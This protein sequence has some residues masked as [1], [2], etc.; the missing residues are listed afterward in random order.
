MTSSLQRIRPQYHFRPGPNGLQA[1]DVR[2]LIA[3]SAA[4]D[5]QQVPLASLQE[6]DETWRYD[7]D[8]PTVRSVV[9]HMRLV[10]AADVSFPILLCADGRLMDGMHRVAR[11]LLSNRETIAARRFPE[12][13]AP[14]FIGVAPSNL[15][16]ED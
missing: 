11:A 5:I 1:W 2:K 15:P 3:A 9:D 13:P 12:T 7:H 10:R 16:Y 4:L 14:D 8:S 6:I